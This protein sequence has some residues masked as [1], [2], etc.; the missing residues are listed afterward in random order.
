MTSN[1]NLGFGEELAWS[2]FVLVVS[3]QNCITG[4]LVTAVN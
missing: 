3:A 4:Y 2:C 1:K